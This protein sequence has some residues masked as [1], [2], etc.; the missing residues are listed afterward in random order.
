MATF[1]N[2]C[3]AKVEDGMMYCPSCGA[4]IY[5]CEYQG[6]GGGGFSDTMRNFNNTADSTSNY[7]SDDIKKNKGMAILA[8]LSWFVF[9]PIFKAKTSKFARFH[10]NQGLVLAITSSAWGIVQ[11]ITTS[12]IG[13]W[14][15]GKIW[16][17]ISTVLCLPYLG[18]LLLA[19]IGIVNA[20]G[21]RA[22][23]L[24]IIGKFRI[25]P[26]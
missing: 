6:G 25:L 16:Y 24:P 18:F 11:W 10:A 3:G 26:Y 14:F 7:S 22:K 4:E 12:M 8:Y 17:V 15:W 2:K 19:I 9:F 21:G 20:V 1:C 5:T 23:E 13:T